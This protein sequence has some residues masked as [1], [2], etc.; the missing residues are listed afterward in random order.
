MQNTIVAPYIDGLYR[1][2][3]SITRNATEAENFVQETYVRPMRAM[4]SL[5]A[6]SNHRSWLLTILR[7]TRI[8]SITA[9]AHSARDRCKRERRECVCGDVTR[10]LRALRGQSGS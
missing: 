9:E 3:M 10:S 1:Y 5:G 7:N 2:A 6:G 4:G 8:N